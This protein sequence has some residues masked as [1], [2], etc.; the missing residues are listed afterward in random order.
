MALLLSLSLVKQRSFFTWNVF[1]QRV[2][3]GW[4][5]VPALS[6]L[7]LCEEVVS[8]LSLSYFFFLVDN[9]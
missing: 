5:G 3:V 9:V 8:P 7:T 2:C 4:G 1:S 6:D